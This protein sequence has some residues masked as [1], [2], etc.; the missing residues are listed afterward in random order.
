MSV[1]IWPY[2]WV[3]VS[4]DDHLCGCCETS[5]AMRK[6]RSLDTE[7]IDAEMH[8]LSKYFRVTCLLYSYDVV[9]IFVLLWDSAL[10]D[11][12]TV[13]PIFVMPTSPSENKPLLQIQESSPSSSSSEDAGDHVF[14]TVL[15]VPLIKYWLTFI[16]FLE[17]SISLVL[18]TGLVVV[19]AILCIVATLFYQKRRKPLP[20][21]MWMTIKAILSNWCVLFFLWPGDAR[22]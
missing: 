17:F 16:S 7:G 19:V 21:N 12:A 5:C 2:S 18:V 1:F 13:G 9:L 8:H 15:I 22:S 11:E 20:F 4:G 10:E 3:A 6:G 14:D